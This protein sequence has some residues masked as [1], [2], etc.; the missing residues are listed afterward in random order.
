MRASRLLFLIDLHDAGSFI[1]PPLS[2]VHG[3][4][5]KLHPIAELGSGFTGRSFARWGASQEAGV[6]TP[7][8][9]ASNDRTKSRLTFVFAPSQNRGTNSLP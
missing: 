5:G 3:G 1:P 7:I 8:L 2:P 6:L 4:G 9:V